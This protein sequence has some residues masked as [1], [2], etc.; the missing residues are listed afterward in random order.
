MSGLDRASIAGAAVAST[1]LLLAGILKASDL[2]AF[3]AAISSWQSLPEWSVRPVI[4]LMPFA[5]MALGLLFLLRV[6]RRLVAACSVAL[7]AAMT[8]AYAIELTSN[9]QLSCGC[10]G[11]WLT[12]A[13]SLDAPGIRFTINALLVAAWSF[14]LVQSRGV[15][16]EVPAAVSHRPVGDAS[17]GFTLV[18]LL[19]V[20]AIVGTLLSLSIWGI[21][22]ARARSKSL[23][24]HSL[25][26][27]AAHGVMA[28][29]ADN[30]GGLPFFA[31]LKTLD[32]TVVSPSLPGP[33][34]VA[35]FDARQVWH[36]PL[37]E[38]GYV[39]NWTSGAFLSPARATERSLAAAILSDYWLPC[40]FFAKR[41]YW[42]TATRLAPSSQFGGVRDADVTWPSSKAIIVPH[43]SGAMHGLP[44]YSD[45]TAQVPM[46][47]FDGSVG[48][49]G[50]GERGPDLGN[51]GA[52]PPFLG[53]SDQWTPGLHT[54]D[55]VA[56]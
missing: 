23:V 16:T 5:E 55:G 37:S 40:T 9:P 14:F 6:R 25:M 51:H 21:A 2:D 29:A 38:A 1:A 30:R 12:R 27:S 13:A 8:V 42:N 10:F 54:L 17:R 43:F 18:E 35:Y 41:E 52:G 44:T 34:R 19:V 7:F 28:Y 11:K 26:R 31:D 45:M 33:Y 3:R 46:A 48:V 32:A 36:I 22:A 47:F 4:V 50:P 39:S 53:G 20:L 49:V 24:E 56:G 15:P